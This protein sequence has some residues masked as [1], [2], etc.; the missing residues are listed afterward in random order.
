[1]I[2]Y[3]LE[4]PLDPPDPP[5]GGDCCICSEFTPENDLSWC[6]TCADVVCG[7]CDCKHNTW[8]A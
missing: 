3:E 2:S 1:M 4:Q 5:E 6:K 7:N 8:G